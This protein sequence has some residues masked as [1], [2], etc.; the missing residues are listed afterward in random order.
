MRKPRPNM[1]GKATK[2]V[3]C[4]NNNIVYSSVSEAASKLGLKQ[5]DISNVL[6]GNQTKTKGYKFV[7]EKEKSFN[8]VR[9]FSK[10]KY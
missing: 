5:G 9:L 3:L 1:I 7:Y 2:S 10:Y 4:L 6:I 8:Y